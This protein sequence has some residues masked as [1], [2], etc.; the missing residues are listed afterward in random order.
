M[1]RKKT[2]SFI[3]R[4]FFTL[5]GLVAL[6]LL[7][8]YPA[9]YV[10]PADFAFFAPLGLAYP[11]VL[12]INI[13]FILFW[14]FK[15]KWNMWLSV[16]CIALGFPLLKD[17]LAFSLFNNNTEKIP[18]STNISPVTHQQHKPEIEMDKEYSSYTV[19]VMTYN[20]RNFDL[21]NWNENVEARNN[22]MQL[23]KG[24]QPDIVCFQEFY[25]ED[26]GEFHNVKMLVNELG[27][28][29]H[30]F[31]KTLTLR[32]K[33]HWGVAVFSRF[34]IIKK[35]KIN[36]DNAQ[37]NVVTYVD[38]VPNKKDT[39]RLFNAHLQSIHLGRKDYKYVEQLKKQV[40]GNAEEK[41]ET[42]LEE[43]YKSSKSI[44]D[45]L[46]EAYTKRGKQAERLSKAVKHSPYPVIVCG[47]F[48][49]TPVSYTYQ[50]IKNSRR[51]T[52]AFLEHGN[53]LGKTF[54]GLLPNLRIDYILSDT[55]FN[56][57]DFNIIKKDFSDHY[58]ISC[59]INLPR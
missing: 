42:N 25:T 37:N 50:T 15:R 18:D 6:A 27:F 41:T 55:L 14:W 16:C 56:V 19:N 26:V 8:T 20:V 36:F 11:F 31:E 2:K 24:E 39:L 21:Y 29:H 51:L 5:N 46:L 13:L 28:K 1:K 17:T 47:D 48:N 10:S 54:P 7:L 53:G 59:Q 22:M 9:A 34:P 12:A 23:I 58:P 40:G 38:I 33:D 35:G 49:D 44:L 43:H 45:K 30:H 4:W 57:R 52:D 3:N 32:N